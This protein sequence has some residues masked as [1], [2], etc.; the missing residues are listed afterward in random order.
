[1]DLRLETAGGGAEGV[2]DVQGFRSV[3]GNDETAKDE[4]DD[5]GGDGVAGDA[6]LDDIA[7]TLGDMGRGRWI[8]LVCPLVDFYFDGRIIN[9]IYGYDTHS[10]P[11]YT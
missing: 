10:D 3:E 1:M 2:E 5:D 9:E 11:I 7:E 6:N 8:V 4:V